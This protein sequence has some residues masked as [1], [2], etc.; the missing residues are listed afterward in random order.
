MSF[1]WGVATSCHSKVDIKNFY[2]SE[3]FCLSFFSPPSKISHIYTDAVGQ[4]VIRSR[5]LFSPTVPLSRGSLKTVKDHKSLYFPNKFQRC[6]SPIDLV[7][8]GSI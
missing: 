6:M 7:R 4:T 5:S 2:K 3:A 8:P 1:L